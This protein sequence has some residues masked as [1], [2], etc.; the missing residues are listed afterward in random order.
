MAL[1][2]EIAELVKRYPTGTEALKGVSLEIEEG[3]FFGLLGPNGAGKST[4]IHCAT[5]LPS[6]RPARSAYSATTRCTTTARRAWP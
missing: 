4:L 3:E 2:L 5:G 6:L 1:A